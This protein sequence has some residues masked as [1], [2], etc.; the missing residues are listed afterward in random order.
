[1]GRTHQGE[2]N[3]HIKPLEMNHL[4]SPRSSMYHWLSDLKLLPAVYHQIIG[5]VTSDCGLDSSLIYEVFLTSGLSQPI[6]HHIWSATSQSHPGWF[7]PAE[8]VSA[9]AL[10]GLAQAEQLN[11]QS[12]NLETVLRTLTL[13]R[14]H[15]LPNPPTPY[16]RIPA[17]R[18]LTDV[19]CPTQPP[20]L[21]SS[22]NSPNH[23]STSSNA[24]KHPWPSNAT[25]N[26]TTASFTAS[27]NL[28]ETVPNTTPCDQGEDDWAEFTSCKNPVISSLQLSLCTCGLIFRLFSVS[29]E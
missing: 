11:Q 29:Y 28:F 4:H 26:G 27:L 12:T 23:Q 1:M 9:L 18:L 13:R 2:V 10:I 20:T 16:V 14:L 25:T 21:R 3:G 17:S 22:L 15:T 7:T 8:L 5:A 24:F 19:H 6:L